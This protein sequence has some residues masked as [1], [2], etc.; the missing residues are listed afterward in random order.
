MWKHWYF[1]SRFTHC[2]STLQVH[3]KYIQS[4]LIQSYSMYR[5]VSMFSDPWT[6]QHNLNIDSGLSWS[7][8]FIFTKSKVTNFYTVKIQTQTPHSDPDL[9][10]D[11]SEIFFRVIHSKRL[12][13]SSLQDSRSRAI[14]EDDSRTLE[15]VCSDTQANSES[16]THTRLML[17]LSKKV[18][19]KKYIIIIQAANVFFL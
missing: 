14:F 12:S 11:F 2:E 16:K 10:W 13:F 18:R 4:I 6:Q 8:D 5:K 17:K 7:F 19:R 15:A 9:L 1:Y 3:G